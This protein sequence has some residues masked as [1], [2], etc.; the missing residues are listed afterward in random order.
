[1]YLVLCNQDKC[2]AYLLH[3]NVKHDGPCLKCLNDKHSSIAYS[4]LL[5]KVV[6]NKSSV[7]ETEELS[8]IRD[9]DIAF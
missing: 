8:Y 4:E 6:R 9:E 3:D 1:M 2:N 7:N 5:D